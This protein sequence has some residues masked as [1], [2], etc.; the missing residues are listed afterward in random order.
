[1]VA[2]LRRLEADPPN[3][4]GDTVSGVE[5]YRNAEELVADLHKLAAKHP[6]PPDA[7]AELTRFVSDHAGDIG[8]RKAG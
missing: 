3:A 6:V 4:M 1:M 8:V 7:W 2:V 5:P